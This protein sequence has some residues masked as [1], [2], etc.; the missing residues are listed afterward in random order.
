MAIGMVAI[1]TS[2]RRH[3]K[4]RPMTAPMMRQ[5]VRGNDQLMAQSVLVKSSDSLVY[6]RDGL[7]RLLDQHCT[8]HTK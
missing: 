6:A 3:P 8:C 4:Q 1:P 2:A 5:T 7:T